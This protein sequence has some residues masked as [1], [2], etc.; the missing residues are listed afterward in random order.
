MSSFFILIFH[1]PIRRIRIMRISQ[2]IFSI[3]LGCA[4]NS[5]V[6]ADSVMDN[7]YIQTQK[8]CLFKSVYQNQDSGFMPVRF[9]R[10]GED[11]TPPSVWALDVSQGGHFCYLSQQEVI[12]WRTDVSQT[13]TL[14]IEDSITYKELATVRF[15]RNKDTKPWPKNKVEL[16]PGVYMMKIGSAYNK[17]IVHQVPTN[18]T[19]KAEIAAWMTKQG[20]TEQAEMY[21]QKVANKPL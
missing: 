10:R 14:V 6:V 8:P 15:R 16:A 21:Q 19:N 3:A 5:A 17:V 4:L 13:A 12:L 20:C 9:R 7:A 1:S 18:Q 2:T 11:D